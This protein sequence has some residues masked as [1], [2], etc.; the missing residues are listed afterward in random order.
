MENHYFKWMAG[1]AQLFELI[2]RVEDMHDLAKTR[3]Q[4][5]WNPYREEITGLRQFLEDSKWIDWQCAICAIPIKADTTD[6]SV[7][8]FV[9]SECGEVHHKGNKT[10][11]QRI[12]EASNRFAKA[13]RRALR[14]DQLRHHYF[15]K[16]Q[17]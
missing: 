6:F 12:V 5:V 1:D 15:A 16:R 10:I 8:N 2:F 9:C 14:H 4:P 7:A 11:D 3:D 17:V 13:Q